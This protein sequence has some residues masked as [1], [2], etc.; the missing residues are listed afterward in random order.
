MNT[1]EK[2]NPTIRFAMTLKRAILTVFIT[3]IVIACSPRVL[4]VRQMADMADVGIT[5]FER[6][7]DLDLVERAIPAHIKLLE[8]LLVNSPDDRRLITLL[9]RL[10]GSYGFGFVETR[11]ETALFVPANHGAASP[12]I[13]TKPWTPWIKGR[14]VRELP[15][16]G[17]TPLH[18]TWSKWTKTMLHPCSGTASTW[19]HGS[20]AISIPSGPYPGR[21]WPG[22]LWN[23]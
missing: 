13:P 9:S 23:G 19:G 22:K 6:D 16:P 17:L 12:D 15:L 11:L 5:A 7:S 2:P 3:A 18:L 1:C 8:G 10:Y 4:I 14:P 21:M 20:I